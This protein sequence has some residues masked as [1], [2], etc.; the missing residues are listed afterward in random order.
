SNVIVVMLSLILVVIVV[1]NVFLW[2]FQMNQ[3]DWEKMQEKVEVLSV[4]PLTPAWYYLGFNYRVQ[5]NITGSSAGVLAD[6]QVAVTIVNGSGLSS[7]NIYYTNHVSQPDFDDVRFTWYNTTSGAE[8]SIPYW[9][10]VVYEGLNASF[11]VK[12]PQI[13]AS[14]DSAIIYVYYG[15][16]TVASASDITSTLEATYTKI[17]LT[18]EWTERVSTTS[19]ATGDDVGSW[20]NIP[21]DF[22]FWR[23]RSK[24]GYT[25]AQMASEFS[26]QRP[27][28]TTGQTA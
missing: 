15:N 28:Q 25:S 7:G 1:A 17:N 20:Q 12:V 3:V 6:Y 13:P 4:A 27:Q 2:Q 9:R 23:E 5:H 16:S 10:E 21:F 26:T 11:W 8:Q 18:Y 19:V 22:P 24:A 14:P